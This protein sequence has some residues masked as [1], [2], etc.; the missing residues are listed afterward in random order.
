M[1][2]TNTS[3]DELYKNQDSEKMPWFHPFLDPD[4]EKYL[5]K[6]GIKKGKVLD[7]GSGPASQSTALFEMGFDVTGVDISHTAIQQSQL[8]NERIRFIHEDIVYLD[9]KE[10]FD[11]IFDRGCFHVIDP[12]QREKYLTVISDLLDPGALY[13]LKV[14]S[15]LGGA[16]QRGPYQ[17]SQ[18]EIQNI[19]SPGFD[20]ID[21]FETI[22]Q[23]QLDSPP[24]ALFSVM[25]KK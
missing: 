17:F 18:S 1:R 13:F 8:K 3:W 24:N 14:F 9:L 21:I 23:G 7:I 19:F 6:L 15:I 11:F 4:L 16:N 25:R 20:I 12:P 5:A 10:K 2:K 22:Y